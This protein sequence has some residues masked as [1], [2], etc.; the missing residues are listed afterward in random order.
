[1]NVII[2][3]YDILN[4]NLKIRWSLKMSS[5]NNHHLFLLHLSGING[6]Y[7]A[8]TAQDEIG[9]EEL[10]KK[11]LEKKNYTYRN[12]KLDIEASLE[13]FSFDTLE[14]RNTAVE[15]LV[16]LQNHTLDHDS[17]KNT[18]TLV[19]VDNKYKEMWEKH[20]K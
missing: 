3:I 10:F 4:D 1:M 14:S 13:H 12:K 18:D 6:D 2:Y 9:E 16:S 15:S 8:S 17:S 7:G 20:Q 11:C 5:P 19:L